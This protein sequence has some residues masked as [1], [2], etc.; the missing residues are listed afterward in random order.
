MAVLAETLSASVAGRRRFQVAVGGSRLVSLLGFAAL[1][2]AWLGTA[3][4]TRIEDQIPWLAVALL[5]LALACGAPVWAL[6]GQRRAVA[7]RLAE[8]TDLL[9]LHAGRAGETAAGGVGRSDDLV[10]SASMVRYHRPACPLA[11]GKRVVPAT[12]S[13]HAAAGRQPCGVCEP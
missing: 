10:A 12:R 13:A 4:L 7:I 2:A 9:E 6:T 3:H 8:V 1:G 5:G 11:A